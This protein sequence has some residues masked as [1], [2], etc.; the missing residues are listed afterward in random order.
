[1]SKSVINKRNYRWG[2]GALSRDEKRYLFHSTLQDLVDLNREA[3]DFETSSTIRDVVPSNRYL[4]AFLLLPNPDKH[5]DYYE[6]IKDP[7]AVLN[8]VERCENNYYANVNSFEHDFQL[9]LRNA[10]AIHDSTSRT[11]RDAA[12]LETAFVNIQSTAAAAL[13][14]DCDIHSSQNAELE[15]ESGPLEV[16]KHGE[17]LL[18]ELCETK[19]KKGHKLVD[20]FMKLPSKRQFRDY[21]DVIKRPMDLATVRQKMIAHEYSTFK[22]LDADIL[23]CFNNAR[24]YNQPGSDVHKDA[25]ALIKKYQTLKM[26]QFGP[27]QHPPSAVGAGVSSVNFTELKK[28]IQSRGLEWEKTNSAVLHVP[29]RVPVDDAGLPI[30]SRTKTRR[31]RSSNMN[32]V[33]KDVKGATMGSKKRSN[34]AT[35]AVSE[36]IELDGVARDTDAV[37]DYKSPDTLDG[38]TKVVTVKGSKLFSRIYACKRGEH[39]VSETFAVL[40]DPNEYADYYTV[41]KDPMDLTTI[42][43]R[44]GI[45]IKAL[46]EGKGTGKG[47]YKSI[48]E[49]IK[50]VDI[51]IKNAT[52]YNMEGSDVYEDAET[53][54]NEVLAPFD[55]ECVQDAACFKMYEALT[56]STVNMVEFGGEIPQPD[57][58]G[59]DYLITNFA[60]L[61]TKSEMP[62]YYKFI[63]QPMDFY[64]IANNLAKGVYAS[65]TGVVMFSEHVHLI[66]TNCQAFNE[67]GSLLH[68]LS[69]ELT[70]RFTK[71]REKFGN[72]VSTIEVPRVNSTRQEQE[73]SV[74]ATKLKGKFKS[75]GK[76]ETGRAGTGSEITKRVK[77]ITE[78][79]SPAK[80][81]SLSATTNASEAVVQSISA[82]VEVGGKSVKSVLAVMKS[83][84]PHARDAVKAAVRLPAKVSTK[85][86]SQEI[87]AEYVNEAGLKVLKALISATDK[88]ENRLISD[89]FMDLPSRDE[90]PDYYE[91]ITR[92]I[93]LNDIKKR[94]I[95][96]SSS[97]SAKPK[98]YKT[99]K[100]FLNDVSQICD[101]AQ[102]Y[103]EA[104]SEVYDDAAT[105]Y[106]LAK[107]QVE[108]YISRFENNPRKNISQVYTHAQPIGSC[109]SDSVCEN[110]PD[111]PASPP[112]LALPLKSPTKANASASVSVKGTHT[113]ST[114]T[115][116]LEV[117][118]AA[119][120][121]EHE[122][123]KGI[124]KTLARMLAIYTYEGVRLAERLDLP[125]LT[126]QS[127][128][129]PITWAELRDGEYSSLQPFVADL[130]LWIQNASRYYAVGTMEYMN[131]LRLHQHFLRKYLQLVHTSVPDA[132]LQATRD[133]ARVCVEIH[134]RRND[135]LSARFKPTI[136]PPDKSL[137]AKELGG[138]RAG[139]CVYL[140]SGYAERPHV[141]LIHKVFATKTKEQ[142]I[143]GQWLA[144]PEETIHDFDRKFMRN[145]LFLTGEKHSNLVSDVIGKCAVLHISEWML[146]E[147]VGV[148]TKDVWIV[149]WAYD[150]ESKKFERIEG[151]PKVIGAS[152]G[153]RLDTREMAVKIPQDT[154]QSIYSE[155]WLHG[156][157]FGLNI[158]LNPAPPSA[159]TQ[160]RTYYESFCW[161][162][163]NITLGDTVYLQSGDEHPYMMLVES[164]WTVEEQETQL[165]DVDSPTEWIDGRWFA[166]P[167]ETFHVPTRTFYAHERLICKKGES[168]P[169][170]SILGKCAVLP[171]KDYVRGRPFGIP[172]EDVYVVESLYDE[173]ARKIER[174]TN[175][176]MPATLVRNDET[177]RSKL[178]FVFLD[179][180]LAN[181]PKVPSPLAP[182]PESP[183]K[184]VTSMEVDEPTVAKSGKKIKERKTKEPAPG[185]PA[186]GRVYKLP[187]GKSGFYSKT[188]YKMFYND[189]KDKQTPEEVAKFTVPEFSHMVSGK[190]KE[191]TKG[192]KSAYMRQSTV[193]NKRLSAIQYIEYD[194]SDLSKLPP[195]T[196]V[197]TCRWEEGPHGTELC[198]RIFQCEEG[199]F[200]HVNADHMVDAL[201]YACKWLGC[202]RN[203]KEKTF[204]RK[205]KLLLHV[206]NQHLRRNDW[207][208]ALSRSPNAKRVSTVSKFAPPGPPFHE[209]KNRPFV[210]APRITRDLLLRHIRVLLPPHPTGEYYQPP[211]VDFFT[212]VRERMDQGRLN[213]QAYRDMLATDDDRTKAIVYISNPTNTLDDGSNNYAYMNINTNASAHTQAHMSTYDQL[214]TQN[215]NV[216]SVGNGNVSAREVVYEYGSGSG[217]RADVYNVFEYGSRG[218]VAVDNQ[219]VSDGTWRPNEAPKVH[220]LHGAYPGMTDAYADSQYRDYTT[221]PYEPHVSLVARHVS[222]S[223]KRMAE[224][225]EGIWRISENSVEVKNAHKVVHTPE[226]ILYKRRCGGSSANHRHQRKRPCTML[227][228]DSLHKTDSSV[229]VDTSG[230]GRMGADEQDLVCTVAGNATVASDDQILR[231]LETL[232]N[233]IK[234]I[235]SV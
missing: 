213:P 130:S 223:P 192:E 39:S 224:E 75:A 63:D 210:D 69:V 166:A 214:H 225:A 82:N 227:I 164:I 86:V 20:M 222:L 228:K 1:M 154:V 122:M 103:N 60:I 107:Q 123:V 144:H 96:T 84:P 111:I 133:Y 43:A 6:L 26:H 29:V 120:F 22:Q 13:N 56:N 215:G 183:T 177:L 185:P 195:N 221:I 92:P 138:Y 74:K 110:A 218:E 7:V 116:A 79:I 165:D 235:G 59:A 102:A 100:E 76:G 189:L 95:G 212:H 66:A 18:T 108:T 234:V 51:M 118:V 178:G 98:P 148:A 217:G 198:G 27:T 158:P 104:G 211:G 24:R 40:P 203:L 101:N 11:F 52:Y 30:I 145:E 169:M 126:R 67:D 38:R 19:D 49:I 93:C 141:V 70:K 21:Y 46:A 219:G 147:P 62:M 9:V 153:V 48:F 150:V 168:N 231:A 139:D 179:Q 117:V 72:P 36:K 157:D 161:Q 128:K 135:H 142:W 229:H 2:R 172:E 162:N 176:T 94:L 181:L 197:L 174:L 180:P 131:T 87:S 209:I 137:C 32:N 12:Y 5:P 83:E 152:G 216:Y 194:E 68:M 193:E 233:N 34:D 58:E 140:E 14:A 10:K 47:A 132:Y 204:D 167:A 143:Y 121:T 230:V 88:K 53:L 182:R 44:L 64:T 23:L 31:E 61:P 208:A 171:L 173:R 71:I 33:T 151:L 97:S 115:S 156:I 77:V 8:I 114:E 73:K 45:S 199:V 232:T 201:P 109:M 146:K 159:I 163:L 113:P 81:S 99:F 125:H 170:R 54:F 35:P 191:L 226:Y 136:D 205:G 89:L 129:H 200:Q 4:D 149:K 160:R 207:P 105:L 65:P 112:K 175:K 134:L 85:H 55:A 124:V 184:V 16:V 78:P 190:W 91:F 42:S 25:S 37:L 188:G 119:P 80:K 50:D 3:Q 187:P 15:T 220:T 90:F 206:K 155:G 196:V 127:T 202:T 17:P 28:C 41:I 57:E 106:H 186:I